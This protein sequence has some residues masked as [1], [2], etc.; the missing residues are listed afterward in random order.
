MRR[1]LTAIVLFFIASPAL[2]GVPIGYK[3]LTNWNCWPQLRLG[4]HSDVASSYDRSG[5]NNDWNYYEFPTGHVTTETTATIKTIQGPGIIYR[6]WMPHIM[7]KNHYAVRMYFDGE[8]TPRIDTDSTAILGGTYSYFSEPL[9]VTFAGGQTC[10]E[11][12]CFS[13]SL[14]IETENKIFGPFANRH[15]YQYSYHTLPANTEINSYTGQLSSEEQQNRDLAISILE[16]AG[17]HPASDSNTAQLM[18][19]NNASIP[20]G[21]RLVFDLTGPGTIRRINLKMDEPNDAELYGLKLKVYYDDEDTSAIDASV[22]YFFG[23][24][25]NRAPYRSLPIGTDSNDGFYCYWPMPFHKSVKVELHNTTIEPIDVN[26]FKIEY[27]PL[28][29]DYDMCYLHAKTNTSVKQSGQIYHTLLSTTGRGHYVGDLLYVQQ[30]TDSFWMLEGDDVITV[31]GNYTQY[32]T[33]LED[34]YNGGAYYNWVAVQEDEPEGIYPQ[35]AS[36]PLNGILYVNKE[37]GLARADQYRWR[38]PDCIPFCSSIDVK[39]ECRYGID[40]SEWT[41]I[42]FWYEFPDIPQDIDEDKDVDFIDFSMFASQW[43]NTNCGDC[44]QAD[45]TGDG[46]VDIE[47]LS[48]FASSWL[49]GASY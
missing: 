41:S 31:D 5:G 47:D 30:N 33:G 18:T 9:L 16:N 15:Y 19:A 11:P 26:L 17:E 1:N 34:A 10:Y 12:I 45:F 43:G 22:G 28:V 42:A 7:S 21:G 13:Q 29:V 44:N 4:I 25:S 37:S 48:D 2:A 46:N 38:I 23:A 40:G 6:F 27:E 39:A 8:T 32:G 36:R 20:S 35:S 49:A 24:G 14:R 3:A